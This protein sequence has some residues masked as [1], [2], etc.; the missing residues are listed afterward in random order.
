MTLR[1][2]RL[3]ATILGSLLLTAAAGCGGPVDVGSSKAALTGPGPCP[4]GDEV[5]TQEVL[6]EASIPSLS[7]LDR[8][9]IIAAVHESVHTDV[10]TIDEAFDAVD[11]GLINR[12]VLRDSYT[13][14]FYVEIE[15]GAGDNSYGAYLYWGTAQVAAAIHDGF[16]EECGPA[17]F[18]YDQGDVAPQCH[19]FLDYANTATF[20][21]LDAYLP[22]DVAQGIVNARASQPFSSVASV[23]AVN[24]VAEARLQQILAAARTAGSVGA[25]CSG[26][27]DQVAVSTAEATAIVDFVN[28]ASREEIRGAL[29]F[30]I[31]QTVAD[32]LTA[33]RPFAG[34]GAVSSTSG[35]GPATFRALRNA[36]T[37]FRPFEQLVDAVNQIDHPDAQ[38]RL[39]QH[40]DWRPLVATSQ[41]DAVS[42]ME[43]FGIDP[44]LLPPGAT[45]RPTLADSDEVLG[46]VTAAVTT[47][48]QLEELSVDPTPGLTDLGARTAGHTS[49]G[50]FINYHPNPWQYDTKTFFVDEQTGASVLIDQHYVE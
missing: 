3:L 11:E 4:M 21:A 42:S 23:V 9:Q 50:C 16:P 24:G 2:T 41:G 14:Q 20:A 22:S 31:N 30:L 8:Q 49:F 28:Q 40:F 34:V 38:I 6:T 25:S 7:D 47:A 33:T 48:N 10:V 45:L 37:S 19:G 18:N 32:T 5:L 44:A 27:Y 36:A 12:L 1:T 13:N 39:D 29:S 46:T 15:Y 35:V 26:I 17:V 43:C